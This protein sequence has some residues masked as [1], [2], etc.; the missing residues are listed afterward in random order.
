[1]L[2]HTFSIYPDVSNSALAFNSCLSRDLRPGRGESPGSSPVF[3]EHTPALGMQCPSRVLGTFQ[4]PYSPKHLISQDFPSQAFLLLV[5][6]VIFC[7]RQ[8][9]IIHLPLNVFDKYL[10]VT[11][12][13]SG[14]IQVRWNKDKPFDL[15]FEGTTRQV[16]KKKLPQFFE[17]K[18]CSALSGTWNLTYNARCLESC[19]WMNQGVRDGR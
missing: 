11:A 4:K 12:L 8:Q 15:V 6:T 19:C 16:K 14:E 18:V 7:P 1:M 9:Q 3:S 5:P 10:Q 13:A 17:N 2:W